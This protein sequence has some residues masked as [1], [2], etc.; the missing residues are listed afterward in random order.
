ML[1][2]YLGWIDIS[3]TLFS[4]STGRLEDI[5]LRGAVPLVKVKAHF[6]AA[7]VNIINFAYNNYDHIADF[8]EDKLLKTEADS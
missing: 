6:I 7:L 1:D 3:E 8:I 5:K 4:A 2:K